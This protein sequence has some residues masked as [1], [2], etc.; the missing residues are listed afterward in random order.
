MRSSPSATAWRT[1]SGSVSGSMTGVSYPGATAPHSRV[2]RD[3]MNASVGLFGAVSA[4]CSVDLWNRTKE[5]TS[6]IDMNGDGFPDRVSLGSGN[7]LN[8]LMNTGSGFTSQRSWTNFMPS[9][10]GD[11]CGFLDAIFED[12][13]NAISE[14]SECLPGADTISG[15]VTDAADGIVSIVGSITKGYAGGDGV[16]A[17]IYQNDNPTPI[18]RHA[19]GPNE[20]TPCVPGPNNTCNNGPLTLTV[21]SSDRLYFRVSSLADHFA[22]HVVWKPEIRYNVSSSLL[23]LREPYGAYIHRY[24]EAE[25]T[26]QV[27]VF[28]V[29]WVSVSQGQVDIEGTFVKQTTSDDVRLRVT[30]V[31]P[32]G[33]PTVIRDQ[34]FP[35]EQVITTPIVISEVAVLPGSRLSFEVLSD[36]AIDTQRAAFR[37]LPQPCQKLE[38]FAL[39]P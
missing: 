24:M 12:L 32:Q 23:D 25:D 14:F 17:T 31:S 6:L 34:T 22:D 13:P 28:T 7:T 3:I 39:L 36:V 20:I 27:G 18:W 38:P 11:E 8:A 15:W 29:P 33:A 2:V 26:Q 9:G 4:N 37:A 1:S 19:I 16:E 35:A 21:R 10:A 30:H 5:V